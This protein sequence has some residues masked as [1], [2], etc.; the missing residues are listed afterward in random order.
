MQNVVFQHEINII[1][2]TRRTSR[3]S[4]RARCAAA[5]RCAG[6]PLAARCCAASFTRAYR[7]V[8]PVNTIIANN[9]N[10]N[11][12]QTNKQT[13]QTNIQRALQLRRRDVSQRWRA[14]VVAH[15]Y[16]PDAPPPPLAR[17]ADVGE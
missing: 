13:K 8:T 16:A 12:K 2:Y 11:N 3:S 14:A 5:R 9:N 17:R 1:E 10:N 15:R 6:V 4:A 7:P